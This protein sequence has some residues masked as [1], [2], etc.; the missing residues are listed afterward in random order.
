MTTSINN[1]KQPNH[2][3]YPIDE[4]EPLLTH[5]SHTQTLPGSQVATSPVLFTVK[6]GLKQIHYVIS[7]DA[8]LGRWKTR[9]GT[10]IDPQSDS[11]GYH[12][13]QIHQEFADCHRD[14]RARGVPNNE[15][16]PMS[17]GFMN[18]RQLNRVNDRLGNIQY[19]LILWTLA[20]I[21]S[22]IIS[23]VYAVKHNMF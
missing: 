17:I 20:L 3:L 13:Y 14:V 22:V 1:N 18:L 23:I 21:V 5:H 12:Y 10:N 4:L 7:M 2:S 11:L 19:M 6:D 15:S 9:T 8:E 16:M